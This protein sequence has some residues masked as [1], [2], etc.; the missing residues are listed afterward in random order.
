MKA[1]STSI[2]VVE[3]KS[4]RL[5]VS[6]SKGSVWS[7]PDQSQLAVDEAN[8]GG[9]VDQVAGGLL[10]LESAVVLVVPLSGMLAVIPLNKK[11]AVEL[12]KEAFADDDVKGIW[13][14]VSKKAIAFMQVVS[15]NGELAKLARYVYAKRDKMADELMTGLS[16]AFPETVGKA[17]EM[18]LGP[19]DLELLFTLMKDLDLKTDK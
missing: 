4:G 1:T 19:E 10:F 5:L 17:A 16:A 13:D 14:L 9:K 18:D 3:F 11:L 2:M 12:L 6:G 7:T 8:L 15:S